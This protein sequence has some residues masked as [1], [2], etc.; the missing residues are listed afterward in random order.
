[1]KGGKWSF[2][3]A[4]HVD[5]AVWVVHDR[6]YDDSIFGTRCNHPPLYTACATMS[7]H[8]ERTF[9]C[10]ADER[11]CC[12]VIVSPPAMLVKAMA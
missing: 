11:L 2:I 12:G 3:E 7:S 9:D 8:S 6:Q 4:M 10:S 5:I 1:M